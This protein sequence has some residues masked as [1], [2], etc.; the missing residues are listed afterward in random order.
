MR[1]GVIAIAYYK[2]LE[3]AL[4]FSEEICKLTHY[5]PRC[6]DSCK[7]HTTH[8]VSILNNKKLELDEL[9]KKSKLNDSRTK[10]YVLENLNKDFVSFNLDDSSSL[11]FTYKALLCA[12][13]GYYYAY[14]FED[15]LLKIINEGGDADTNGC[16]I[17]T[18]LGARFGIQSIDSNYLIGINKN[19]IIESSI[20]EII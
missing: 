4:S 15:G 16:V 14:S 5:D 11:G 2:D 20:K 8:L 10:K 13:W 12:L 3:K 18:V 1:N 9:L 17:G 7:I 6:I 19:N